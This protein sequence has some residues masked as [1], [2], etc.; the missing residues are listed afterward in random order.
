MSDS[1][2]CQSTYLPHKEDFIYWDDPDNDI[3]IFRLAQQYDSRELVFD[4]TTGIIS[5]KV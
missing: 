2:N 4:A 1:T 3:H 5:V